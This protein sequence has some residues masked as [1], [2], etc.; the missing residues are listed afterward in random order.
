MHFVENILFSD[1]NGYEIKS[2]PVYSLD[3]VSWSEESIN[4]ARKMIPEEHGYELLQGQGSV[5]GKVLGGCLDV[6]PMFIGTEIWPSVN[7]WKDKIL[8][9]ETS[10]EKPSPDL[11]TYYL[12]NLG[13]QGIFDAVKGILVGKPQDEMY[14]EEYKEVFIKVMKEFHREDLPI[15]YNINIGHAFPTG[16][17]PLGL[18]MRI[19]FMGKRI[20][21]AE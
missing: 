5:T 6:F 14:Y 17:I 20:I 21:I 15:L 10:E 7:E 1:S 3:H 12:R 8:L 9:L 13:A 16:I 19:D 11:V 18:D 2:S 4:T